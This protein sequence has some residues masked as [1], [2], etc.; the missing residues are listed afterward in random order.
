M[1]DFADDVA[2]ALHRRMRRRRL[3]MIAAAAAIIAFAIY[4]VTCGHG[5]GLGGSGKGS[6]VGPATAD[7]GPRRCIVRVT[8]SG[9]V[10]DGKPA[11]SRDA[12]VTTCRTTTGAEVTVTGDARQ[13]D[14]DDLRGALEAAHVAILVKRD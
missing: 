10:L 2:R 13:G 1:T 14:W 3:A 5:F 12:V 7:A 6:G 11:A 9:Y 8:A 4:F